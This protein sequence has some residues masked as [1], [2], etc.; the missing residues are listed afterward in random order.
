MEASTPSVTHPGNLAN[1]KC[2]FLPFSLLPSPC[3]HQCTRAIPSDSV[4]YAALADVFEKIE[5]VT[6]RLVIQELLQKFLRC[7]LVNTPDDLVTC[8]YL[9]CNKLAP[10]YAA[11]IPSPTHHDCCPHPRPACYPPQL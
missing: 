10:A 4:P 2:A 3:L 7:V 11:V 6:K 5:A 1:R 9:C 8:V